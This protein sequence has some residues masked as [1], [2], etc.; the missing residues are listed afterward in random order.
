[1]SNVPLYRVEVSF[2]VKLLD[3]ES[4]VQH[5]EM[6]L[7][8]VVRADIDSYADGVS[9]VCF[10]AQTLSTAIDAIDPM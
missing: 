4:T 9:A 2:L 3:D 6:K 8:R 10:V 7:Q 5:G 1:M